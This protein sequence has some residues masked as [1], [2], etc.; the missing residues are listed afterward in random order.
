MSLLTDA[1]GELAAVDGAYSW[2]GNNPV[3]MSD[4]SRRHPLTDA[5]FAS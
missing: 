2:A 3:G 1:L 5:E 4:P